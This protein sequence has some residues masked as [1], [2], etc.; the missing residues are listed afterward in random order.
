MFFPY[1]VIVECNWSANAAVCVANFTDT[2]AVV[3][4]ATLASAFCIC[5]VI[6]INFYIVFTVLQSVNYFL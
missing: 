5:V 4:I 6:I 3:V 2:A 1:S